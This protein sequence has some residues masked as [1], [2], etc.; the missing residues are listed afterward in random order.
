MESLKL[1]REQMSHRDAVAW[2]ADK[3]EILE[4]EIKELFGE[5]AFVKLYAHN[6]EA[7]GEDKIKEDEIYYK[8]KVYYVVKASTIKNSAVLGIREMDKNPRFDHLIIT[9]NTL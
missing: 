2:I 7:P 9:Y 8:N 6:L 1:N 3:K 5:Q 4:N